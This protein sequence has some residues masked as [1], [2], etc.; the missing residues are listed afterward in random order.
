[1]ILGLKFITDRNTVARGRSVRNF[2]VS[3]KMNLSH[4]PVNSKNVAILPKKYYESQHI[5]RR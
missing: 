1:M 2:T 3:R 5:F 4:V